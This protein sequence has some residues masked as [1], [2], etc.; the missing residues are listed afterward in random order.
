MH[1]NHAMKHAHGKAAKLAGA[2]DVPLPFHLDHNFAPQHDEAFVR[3]GV[4]MRRGIVPR[5]VGLVVP[6][7][8]AIRVEANRIPWHAAR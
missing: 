6:D 8:Q 3:F 5:L 4:K 2:D 7:L 1:G